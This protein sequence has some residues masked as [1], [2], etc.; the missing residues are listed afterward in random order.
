MKKITLILLCFFAL[1]SCS[2]NDECDDQTFPE[3]FSKSY[4]QYFVDCDTIN[5][6]SLI[7]VKINEVEKIIEDSKEEQALPDKYYSIS[8]GIALKIYPLPAYIGEKSPRYTELVN[9]IGDTSY[10]RKTWFA[11]DITVITTKLESIVITCDKDFSDDLPA[12]SDLSGVFTVCYNSPYSLIKNNYL[13]PE[14]AYRFSTMRK[15]VPQIVECGKLNEV[16]FI[17][18]NYIGYEWYCIFNK[19]PDKTGNYTFNI[20]VTTIE[21]K[22]LT[23]ETYLNIKGV[24]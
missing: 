16:N 9:E 2:D 10:N 12:G 17:E 18:K 11:D 6:F 21:G 5:V 19:L 22:K 23:A 24:G 14:E 1:W 13:E 3:K 20:T 15:E 4:I 8:D 7:N